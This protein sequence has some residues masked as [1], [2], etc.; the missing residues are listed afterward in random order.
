[1]GL[2]LEDSVAPLAQ[3][4]P[5]FPIFCFTLFIHV[6]LP[7][8]CFTLYYMIFFTMCIYNFD[9]FGVFQSSSLVS[10]GLYNCLENKDLNHHTLDS[11][12]LFHLLICLVSPHHIR[13]DE[14]RNMG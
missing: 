1:M 13:L 10:L 4:V 2:I 6:S 11:S 12:P 14:H 8:H 5:N 7:L 3:V 9:L